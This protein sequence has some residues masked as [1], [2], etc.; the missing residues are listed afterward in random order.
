LPQD[1]RDVVRQTRRRDQWKPQALRRIDEIEKRD[2]ARLGDEL[3]HHRQVG[4]D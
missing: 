3:F 4:L 2:F 1:T